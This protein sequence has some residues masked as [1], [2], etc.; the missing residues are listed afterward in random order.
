LTGYNT[1]YVILFLWSGALLSSFVW[2]AKG[3]DT[4]GNRHKHK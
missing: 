2:A 1:W 3:I 4:G